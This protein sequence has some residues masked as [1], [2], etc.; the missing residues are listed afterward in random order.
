VARWLLLIPKSA[1]SQRCGANPGSQLATELWKVD[2]PVDLLEVTGHYT[3]LVSD[4][5]YC[6]MIC[7]NM[8]E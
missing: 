6:L 4:M 1:G 3:I 7:W 2:R 8:L 5:L